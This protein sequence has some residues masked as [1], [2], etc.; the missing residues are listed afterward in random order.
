MVERLAARRDVLVL[1]PLDAADVGARPGARSARST[2]TARCCRSFAVARPPTGPCCTARV[3]DRRDA[4]P[5]W[6]RRP[7][8]ADIVD[9]QSVPI[10][11]DDTGAP[12]VRQGHGRRR[13]GALAHPAVADARRRRFNERCSTTSPPA[14]TSAA[15]KPE[16]GRIDW[17]AAGR[18]SVY[19]LIRAV[20]PP[21]PGAFTDDRRCSKLVVGEG[22]PDDVAAEAPDTTRFAPVGLARRRCGRIVGRL[23]RRPIASPCTS[24]L[25]H[26]SAVASAR[27][28]RSNDMLLKPATNAPPH[29]MKK[30]LILGVNGFIGHHLTQRILETTDWEVYGMDMASQPPRRHRRRIRACISSR[31]TSRSTRSGSSTT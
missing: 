2:C 3:R 31:A 18:P 22:S 9:Q 1:L 25:L 10:L 19:N 29:A 14:A 7:T 6:S 4:A 30:I 5:R 24:S 11:P 23:R 16:D 15:R 13:A 26:D 20:A 12:G 17:S 28:S 8:R 21:Y 27:R